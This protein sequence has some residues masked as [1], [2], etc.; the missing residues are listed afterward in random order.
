[1]KKRKV[2]EKPS[3]K[4]HVLKQRARLLQASGGVQAT[5]KNGGSFTETDGWD[6]E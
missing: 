3:M 5:M 1:M 6:E 2:Y 4:V